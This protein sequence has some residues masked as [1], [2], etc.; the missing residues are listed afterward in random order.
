VEELSK[1]KGHEEE[2]QLYT[3]V[4]RLAP[5]VIGEK[6]QIYKGVSANVDFYSGFVYD[7]LELPRELF[8]PIF[9]SARSAGWCAHR[10]EELAGKGKI[11]RPAYKT[12]QFHDERGKA[13]T[14]RT[15]KNIKERV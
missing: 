11:I 14:H 6:R 5:E 9:A 3:K 10:M 7:M 8:N 15:Y 4:E 13:I 2:F 1:E 12:V